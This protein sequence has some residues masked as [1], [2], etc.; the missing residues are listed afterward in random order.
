VRRV[1]RWG[2]GLVLLLIAVLGA[3]ELW[4]QQQGHD[5]RQAD[6][7]YRWTGEGEA[8]SLTWLGVTAVLLRDG[9]HAILIDPF[10]T[11]PEGL[12]RLLGN[13]RIAPDEARITEGLAALGVQ[14]LDAVLVSHSHFDHAMDAGVVSRQTGARLYGS[15][16]TLQ[17]GRG[18]GLDEAQL[19]AVVPG[20]PYQIG[21]FTLRFINSRHAGATGGRPTGEI[22][23]PLQPPATYL[24]YRLGGTYSL[25]IENPQ[26]SVL[27]HGSA[28]F[29]PGALAP[30]QA[31]VVLLGIAL[32]EDLPRYL[33]ETV[34]AV[35]ARRVIPTHWDDFTR[36]LSEPLQPFPIG[37]DLPGFLASLQ[38][39]RPDLAVGTLV[40]G[41][42]I[43]VFDAP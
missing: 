7:H 39:Q 4:R 5:A 43:R 17:I 2:A 1:V 6:A 18:A 41:Q 27:H 9:E 28:G 34:D 37:V 8:L 14:R 3:I 15:P 31:D 40:P 23:A 30:Y 25:L 38:A 10:F 21:P 12:W 19:Q 11:R 35:G 13:R 16:S 20:M 26:V 36:P 22:T 29:I 33:A 42:P 32:I 24:D